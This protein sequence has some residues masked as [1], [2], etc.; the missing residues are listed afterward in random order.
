MMEE[1]AE[2]AGHRSSI[3]QA[4]R[5]TRALP[6]IVPAASCSARWSVPWSENARYCNVPP[7]GIGPVIHLRDPAEPAAGRA[8]AWHRLTIDA[9]TPSVL[10]TGAAKS[11]IDR[12]PASGRNELA[13]TKLTARA[14]FQFCGGIAE[15]GCGDG[16]DLAHQGTEIRR[17][18][19]RHWAS[20]GECPPGGPQPRDRNLLP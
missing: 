17:S 9:I 12:H 20:S 4:G 1:R 16:I 6:S 2:L 8:A 3:G 11:R 14:A 19:T 7:G 15:T 5:A 18:R 10:L 13:A